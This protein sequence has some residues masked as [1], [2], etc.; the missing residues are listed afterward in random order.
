MYTIQ[1]SFAP[2]LASFLLN[3][4]TTQQSSQPSLSV[5]T[6]T[7]G[8]REHIH[9]FKAMQMHGILDTCGLLE[10]IQSYLLPLFETCN[11]LTNDP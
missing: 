2:F 8:S 6:A 1:E 3:K 4:T 9:N 7:F 11:T 10:I 5:G